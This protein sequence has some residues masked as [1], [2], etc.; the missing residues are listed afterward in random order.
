LQ[1]PAL[2]TADSVRVF[3]AHILICPYLCLQSFHALLKL[4]KPRIFL[5]LVLGKNTFKKV[6]GLKV[7]VKG[8]NMAEK[9]S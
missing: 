9:K 6:T 1:A 5:L 3:N 8:T 7:S 2:K 4:K